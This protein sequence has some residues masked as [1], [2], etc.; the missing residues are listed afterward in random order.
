MLLYTSHISVSIYCGFDFNS[1]VLDL[2]SIMVDGLHTVPLSIG[3]VLVCIVC[4]LPVVCSVLLRLYLLHLI[5]DLLH[6]EAWIV[7]LFVP[8]TLLLIII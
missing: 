3:V 4:M 7:P 8:R 5:L 2:H 6:N 1:Y